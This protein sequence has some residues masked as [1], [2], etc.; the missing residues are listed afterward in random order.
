M[1]N[2]VHKSNQ[3]LSGMCGW[4]MLVMMFLLTLDILG[5]TVNHPLQGMAELSVFV[6]MIVIYLGFSRCE[7][8]QEHVGLKVVVKSLPLKARRVVRVFKHIL[9][10][11]A[12]ALLS[13]AVTM[14]A[15][16]AYEHNSSLEGTMEIPIW[17]VKFIM[18]IGML[19]FLLQSII[20][21]I[22]D[23]KRGHD[24]ITW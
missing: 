20:N 23:W 17:P 14:D 16:S 24:R 8:H 15:W 13:Y 1:K 11:I 3:I 2:F 7:E 12:V 21:L 19:F 22:Q 6:M 10:V 4:L 9:A 18:V 5:R